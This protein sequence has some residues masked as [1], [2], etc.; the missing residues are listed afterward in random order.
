MK[1]RYVLSDFRAIIIS[2]LVLT[3]LFGSM[4][5]FGQAAQANLVLYLPLD[6]GSGNKTYDDSGNGHVGIVV[7]AT[8][9]TGIAGNALEF[10]GEFD[11]LYINNTDILNSVNSV[12]IAC[13]IKVNEATTQKSIVKTNGFKLF[14]EGDYIG[15]AISVPATNNASGLITYDVWTQITGTYDGTDI[16]FYIDGVLMETKNW[17]GT[18]S[19]GVEMLVIA[20]DNYCWKGAIDEVCVWNKALTAEEV[21]SHYANTNCASIPISPVFLAL[22]TLVGTIF[23]FKKRK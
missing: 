16:K 19:L 1:K 14:H 9:I 10:D 20:F 11:V 2:V 22:L 4:V 6:E 23:I 5:F 13:W 3:S 17:P 15:L 8:W 7:G 21:E 18:M 12:T